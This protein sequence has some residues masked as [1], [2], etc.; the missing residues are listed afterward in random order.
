MCIRDSPTAV[1]LKRTDF[2]VKRPS[3]APDVK[4]T[5]QCSE[6]V[7]PRLYGLPKIH[8]PEVLLWPIVSAIGSLT[9]N[10]A[11]IL[12]SVGTQKENL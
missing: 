6:A 1:H 8:K 3:V 2:L 7:P 9:Y 10:L 5:V 4:P 11:C 12:L